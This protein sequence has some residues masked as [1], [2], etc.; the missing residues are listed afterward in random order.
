MEEKYRYQFGFREGISL[1]TLRKA[2]RFLE[3]DYINYVV[4]EDKEDIILD[5]I[6]TE[7]QYLLFHTEFDW[8]IEW[9]DR[10]TEGSTPIEIRERIKDEYL[11]E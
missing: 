5:V 9:H 2:L 4:G 1:G 3:K 8:A 6:M 7:R 11:D 10:I